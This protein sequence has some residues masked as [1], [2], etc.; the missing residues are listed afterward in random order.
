[1]TEQQPPAK[2]TLPTFASRAEKAAFWDTHDTT[3]YEDAFTP[4]RVRFAQHLSEGITIRLDK[5]T[6]RRLRERAHATGIGP[7]T[8]ARMW[9]LEASA[10]G[11]RSSAQRRRALAGASTLL[12]A[13]DAAPHGEH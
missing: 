12:S 2:E 8:L 10:G 6:L 9:V 5:E 13:A 7:T 4:A 3:D 1:M 11:A